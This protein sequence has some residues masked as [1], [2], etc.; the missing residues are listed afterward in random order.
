MS[1]VAAFVGLFQH[2]SIT[3][4][5]SYPYLMRLRS[6]NRSVEFNESQTAKDGVRRFAIGTSLL[7]LCTSAPCSEPYP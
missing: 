6:Y 5:A 3:V 2:K 4:S 1:A 7:Y